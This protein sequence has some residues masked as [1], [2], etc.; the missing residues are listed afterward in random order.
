MTHEKLQEYPIKENDEETM[1]WHGRNKAF[2]S[3]TDEVYQGSPFHYTGRN[4]ELGNAI[5]FL[6]IR[7]N[8]K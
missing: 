3:Q 7:E 6:Y 5:R 1:C 2:W 4:D 8:D